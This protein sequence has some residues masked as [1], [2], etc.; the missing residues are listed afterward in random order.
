[1]RV[2][3]ALAR[4]ATRAEVLQVGRRIDGGERKRG[5]TLFGNSS[6]QLQEMLNVFD[7]VFRQQFAIG[8]IRLGGL[9]DRVEFLLTRR[10]AEDEQGRQA[11]AISEENVRFQS[12]C[13]TRTRAMKFDHRWSL[14]TDRQPSPFGW[15]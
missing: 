12:A 1:M 6:K 15:A 3:V 9:L 7:A 13:S 4:A 2:V 5:G 14:L 8:G 11:L 10:T